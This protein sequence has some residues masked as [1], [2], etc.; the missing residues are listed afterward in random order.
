MTIDSVKSTSWQQ[1]TVTGKSWQQPILTGKSWQQN[2]RQQWLA[3]QQTTMTG[4][5]TKNIS[6]SKTSVPWKTVLVSP[7]NETSSSLVFWDGHSSWHSLLS[8]GQIKG[9]SVLYWSP[10][11]ESP[12]HRFVDNILKSDYYLHCAFLTYFTIAGSLELSYK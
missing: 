9:V 7:C 6:T 10:C 8:G 4:T 5:T 11:C 3:K 2:N 1:P 12:H